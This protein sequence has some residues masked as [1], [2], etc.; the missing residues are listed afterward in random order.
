MLSL[1]KEQKKR[2]KITIGLDPGDR[3]HRF[4]VLGCNGEVVEEGSLLNE[5]VQLSALVGRY[6][7]AL[8][9]M[10]AGSHRLR[11]MSGT[12]RFGMG[13]SSQLDARAPISIVSDRKGKPRDRATTTSDELSGLFLRD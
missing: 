10:E 2:D 5:R 4:C 9:V 13:P 3:R 11:F 6:P 1:M 12:Y 7:A 8:V